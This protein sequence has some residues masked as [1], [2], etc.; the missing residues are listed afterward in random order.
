MNKFFLITTVVFFLSGCTA[1]VGSLLEPSAEEEPDPISIA[2]PVTT[3]VDSNNVSSFTI[4]G[5]CA[6]SDSLSVTVG[7]ISQTAACDSNGAWTVTLDLSSL[8]DGTYS[9][10]VVSSADSSSNATIQITKTIAVACVGGPTVFSNNMNARYVIGQ[11]DFVAN[12]ANRGGVAAANTLDGPVGI[13]VSNGKLY[14]ADSGNN[15]VLVF[16]TLPTSN[17]VAADSVIGQP[18]F[19][20]TA[21]GTSASAMAG[22]QAIAVDG[23][24]LAV[25]EWSNSRVSFWP[26]AS[27]TTASFF[28][29][30]PDATTNTVN[31]GGI[32]QSSLGA[33]AGISFAAGKFFVGDVSNSRVLEFS[34]AS[35]STH[36]NA[37]NVIGQT[38]YVSS[39]TGGGATGFGA[40]YSVSSDGTHL[41]VMDN[42]ADR[43]M[44]YNSIPS[45][46]GGTAD[47][48]WGGFGVDSTHLNNPVGVFVGDNKMF[49]ADRSSDR[50][51][52]FNSIP[53]SSAQAADFVLGQQNF[54]SSDNNQCNCATA[55]A[56]TLWGVHH[57][58]WDGCRLY[59]TDKQNNRVLIY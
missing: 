41:V 13:A 44:I 39:A 42:N 17:G 14:V 5:S 21:S 48:T 43:L 3:S 47:V 33:V 8:A 28:W 49:V 54:T 25:G 2:A 20:G 45:A 56:N 59:V 11:A 29:G 6:A 10:T 1:N 16:N 46:P 23:T 32:G 26:L 55:A 34:A 19:A 36:Q 58:Y 50:V 31:T 57:V 51:L 4:A 22:I 7:S 9:I 35:M 12:S 38:D 18:N 37:T 40:P 15:R 24:H 27:S 30:Q 52:V 53:T